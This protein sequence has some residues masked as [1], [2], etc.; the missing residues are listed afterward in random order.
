MQTQGATN[1]CSQTIMKTTQKGSVTLKI[2]VTIKGCSQTIIKRHESQDL[3]HQSKGLKNYV[4]YENLGMPQE[5][6]NAPVTADIMDFIWT[7]GVNHV[8]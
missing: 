5:A 8:K 3:Q 2:Q 1:G 7:A 4:E 6:W